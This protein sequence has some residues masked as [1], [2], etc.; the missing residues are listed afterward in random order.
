MLQVSLLPHLSFASKIK[1][2]RPTGNKLPVLSPVVSICLMTISSLAVQSS[3]AIGYE[4]L[5]KEEHHPAGASTITGGLGQ[6]TK[7]GGVLSG[8]IF[9]T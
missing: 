4:K 3:S 5:T 9:P 7:L 8:G 2:V 6:F 1:V